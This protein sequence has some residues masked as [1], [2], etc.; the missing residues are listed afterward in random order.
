M[1]KKKKKRVV[2]TAD[3]HC[4]HIA[5]LT[6]P[7]WWY[8]PGSLNPRRTAI[9]EQQKAMW[10]WYAKTLKKLQPI[11]ILFDLGDNI[12]G[13]GLKSGGTEQLTCDMMEQA[14]MA[15]V[16]INEAH[17]P[18]IE[19]VYGT[20]YHTGLSEDMEEA[21]IPLLDG[22][23][24]ISGQEWPGVNGVVFDIKHF[25]G[26]SSIPHGGHTAKAK[27]KLWNLIWAS[28]D[29]QPK[30]D[31]LLRG[32][33]HHYDYDYESSLQCLGITCPALQGFGSKFGVRKC[34]GIVDMGLLVFDIEAD[35]SVNRWAELAELA[36][37]RDTVKEL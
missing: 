35:G 37:H 20:G 12:D 27:S 33:V 17:A 1:P 32:H 10:E 8:N 3:K 5:G 7:D 22:N 29:Q 19:L 21:I 11:D 23:A 14:E 9:Y 6:P 36:I 15:A 2:V 26:N 13:K 34:E 18:V 30:A 28:R 4:G 24:A 25:I 31:V 16:C